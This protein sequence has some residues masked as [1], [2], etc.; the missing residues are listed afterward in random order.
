MSDC[1]IVICPECSQE[2]YDDDI[3][4]VL[5]KGEDGE[6]NYTI[7]CEGC[8][9]IHRVLNIGVEMKKK[10]YQVNV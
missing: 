2:Y 5:I 3:V 7:M 4:E 1:D 9:S 6:D 10:I 8:Y